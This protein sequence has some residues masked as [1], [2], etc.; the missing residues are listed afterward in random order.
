MSLCPARPKPNALQPY[1]EKGCVTIYQGDCLNVLPKL[2]REFDWVVTDPPYGTGERGYGRQQ[3]HGNNGK[4]RQIQNDESLKPF[5]DM[6]GHVRSQ[7]ICTFTHPK[8]LAKV[9]GIFNGFEMVYAAEFIWNKKTAG[10]G[11]LRYSHETILVA[12]MGQIEIETHKSI[13]D[14]IAPARKNLHPHEK[15]LSVIGSLLE[16]LKPDSVIDPFL[17]SGTTAV[18]CLERGIPFVGIEIEERWAELAAHRLS[19][20]ILL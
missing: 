6:V 2:D 1:F 12:T 10:L 15:P 4:G 18:A 5:R 17:G 3:N 13:F 7:N 14:G 11:K 8:K 19:Q 20:D 16:I 9:I